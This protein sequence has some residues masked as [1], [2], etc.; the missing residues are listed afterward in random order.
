MATKRVKLTVA[1]A[2]ALAG[3]RPATWRSYV[4]RG[5]RPAPDGVADPCGCPWWWETTIAK[6]V[7]AR[8]A[9]RKP[10]TV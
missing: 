2:A 10:T 8:R 3:V 5:Q 6:D 4:A 7:A 9:R 1:E